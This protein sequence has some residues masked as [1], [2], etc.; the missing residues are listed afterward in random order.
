M[1]TQE[2][3]ITS[4]L[5]RRL[6][7][8]VAVSDIERDIETRL[9]KLARTVKMSGF[10]PGKVPFK[11][12]AQQYG[13]QVR[14]EAIGEAVQK[15]FGDAVREQN[16]RVAGMPR[17]EHKEVD[18]AAKLEFSAVF[19]V[20]PDIRLG[21]LSDKEIE[22]PVLEV[23]ETE[24][25]KTVEVLRKQRTTFAETARAAERGDRVVV[26]FTGRIGGEVFHGGQA[27]DF[28]VICGTGS[29]LPDFE[30]QIV[31]A[32]AG[33]NRTFDVVFPADYHAKDLAGKTAQFEVAIKRVEQPQLPE[34]D[35]DFAKSLGIADGDL[36]RMRS[37]IKTNLEREVSKR[38]RSRVKEQV[39]KLLLEA[40][41]IEVP[42]TLVNHEALQLA[43]NARNDLRSRG[44]DPK[45]I[46]VDQRWFG[47]QAERRVK[48]GLILAEVASKNGLHAK[49]EQIRAMV[50]DFAQSYEDPSEV[51]RW[52][53]SE[54]QQLARVEAFVIEENVV[55]WVMKNART[56][57]KPIAFDQLM[58]AA[59]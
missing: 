56:T 33:E 52:Y 34:V 53:Y 39:M 16:I 31:G 23:G 10:R 28:P 49:P 45:N 58:G 9:K 15:A 20:Y 14:S 26:D 46:G 17:F 21:D 47:E 3:T 29:M 57:D 30:S 4:P 25:D 51:V 50:D 40:N 22:R 1:Q 43:E 32:V 11:L 24:V 42:R 48:I 38:L 35:V 6:D 18:D 19:E 41:P 5:E 13:V 37:E 36:Q 8:A 55:D 12:V 27:S 54:R 7:M 2:A 44:I 59:A